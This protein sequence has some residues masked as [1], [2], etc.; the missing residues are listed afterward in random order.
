MPA[1]DETGAAFPADSVNFVEENDA[2]RIFLGLL[3]QVAHTRSSDSYE[4]LY[5]IAAGY[6]KERH[7]CLTGY[8][9]GQ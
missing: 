6:A 2:W 5:K 7:I 4:H 3:K 8:C 1:A 9:F